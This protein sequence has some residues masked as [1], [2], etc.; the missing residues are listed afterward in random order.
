MLYYP[1]VQGPTA[2]LKCAVGPH[3]PPIYEIATC[4]K[5]TLT[6]CLRPSSTST[7]LSP[8]AL[9]PSRVTMQPLSSPV[10][11]NTIVRAMTI[12]EPQLSESKT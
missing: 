10:A 11:S 8:F 12:S 6:E 5:R 3:S 9:C 7:N 1:L 4:A 2:H